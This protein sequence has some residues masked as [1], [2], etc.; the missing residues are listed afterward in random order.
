MQHDGA[1]GTVLGNGEPAAAAYRFPQQYYDLHPDRGLN[2]QLNRMYGWV[3]EDRM[4]AEIREAAPA[5]RNY[6]DW[7]ET[8]TRLADAALAARRTPAA[9]YYVRLAEFFMF[10]GDPR[11]RSAR[12]RFVSLVREAHGMTESDRILVPFA[13]AALPAYRFAAPRA[14]G[15]LVV[16]GGYDSYIEEWFPMLLALRDAG[17]DVIAFE[18]PGQGGALEEF[19]LHLTPHW[20]EPVGAVLDHFAERDVTLIGLS[21][22]GCLVIR[23]AAFEPRVRRAIAFDAMTD[24]GECVLH[25]AASGARAAALGILGYAPR[26]LDA[27]VGRVARHD[28][29]VEWGVRQGMHVMGAASPHAYF[30][31]L[32]AY[33]T[34]RVSDRVTQDVLLLCGAEDHYVPLRQLGD[35]MRMLTNAASVSSR[36]FTR[37]DQAQNHCQIGNLGLALRVIAGWLDTL[38][39]R[40]GGTGG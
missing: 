27:V 7:T 12:D 4:L 19:G 10:P 6:A 16:F 39:A 32:S 18:G 20:N 11:K 1:S 38:P 26:V 21:L 30:D 13:G 29:M 34:R 23:A 15:T 2:F 36:T 35:Q 8:F 28:L 25:T 17:Y 14:K 3:G 33:T 37:A 24:F 40:A 9:A 5:I 22:G 31:A